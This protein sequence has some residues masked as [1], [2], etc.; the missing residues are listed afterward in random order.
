MSENT[1]VSGHSPSDALNQNERLS[2]NSIGY[3]ETLM[4]R[5]S[6]FRPANEDAIRGL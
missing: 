5:Q 2:I 3:F 4:Y 1:K 6:V